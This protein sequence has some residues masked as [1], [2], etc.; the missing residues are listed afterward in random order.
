MVAKNNL[1]LPLDPLVNVSG[2]HDFCSVTNYLKGIAEYQKSGDILEIG[3]VFPKED[4]DLVTSIK[5]FR[6]TGSKNQGSRTRFKVRQIGTNKSL[7]IVRDYRPWFDD[8]TYWCQAVELIGRE[9]CSEGRAYYGNSLF[10]DG[11]CFE[12]VYGV[13]QVI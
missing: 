9:I 8:G 4:N 1:E 11:E 10:D 12:T 2:F 13:V 3:C 5:W 6:K 7:L